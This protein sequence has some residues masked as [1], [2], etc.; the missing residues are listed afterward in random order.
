MI[1]NKDFRETATHIYFWGSIYSQW[2]KCFFSENGI[3]FN[4][5]EQYMMY[6]KALTFE[7]FENAAKVL[8]AKDP[9]IQKKLGKKVK[10]FNSENWDRLRENIVTQGNYLKFSQ[11][12]ELKKELLSHNKEIVEASPYDK[13]YGIGLHYS[14]DKVLDSS[15]WNGQNLLGICIMRAKEKILKEEKK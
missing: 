6:H 3:E 1:K 12:S 8:E 7:D 13:I 11:N 2:Y 9:A 5:S 4:C 14:D 10:N 15:L